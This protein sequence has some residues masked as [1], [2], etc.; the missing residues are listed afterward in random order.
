MHEVK[1]YQRDLRR[2]SKIDMYK[3]FLPNQSI[4]CEY[5]TSLKIDLQNLE[6]VLLSMYSSLR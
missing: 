4:S 1:R 5:Q 2:Y 3:I 6:Y